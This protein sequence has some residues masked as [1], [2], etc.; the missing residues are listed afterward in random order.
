VKVGEEMHKAE[1]H[2]AA[3]MEVVVVVVKV[4]RQQRR[5]QQWS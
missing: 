4:V 5:R 2:K 1:V 3:Y